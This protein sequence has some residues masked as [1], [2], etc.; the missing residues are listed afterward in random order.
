MLRR[1]VVEKLIVAQLVKESCGF[2]RN[3]RCV[4]VFIN[5]LDSSL[6]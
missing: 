5:A 6:F 1:S 2:L 3:L 4:T